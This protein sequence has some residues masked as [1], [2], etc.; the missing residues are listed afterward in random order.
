[1]Y[2]CSYRVSSEILLTCFSNVM[3]WI[4][5]YSCLLFSMCRAYADWVSL[6]FMYLMCSWYCCLKLCLIC[7]MCCVTDVA[8]EF[9]NAAF[10]VL[11]CC[12]VRRGFYKL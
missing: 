7:P 10:F 2:S 4:C 8:G 11:W 6:L 3:V 1:M 12:V 5:L 9:V